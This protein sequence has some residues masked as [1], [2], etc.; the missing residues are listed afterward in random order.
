[1]GFYG[2]VVSWRCVMR[3]KKTTEHDINRR[4]PACL[5]AD[6][7][8]NTRATC[9]NFKPKFVGIIVNSNPG[10]FPETF[11]DL[12][13]GFFRDFFFFFFGSL[14]GVFLEAWQLFMGV[15]VR[16]WCESWRGAGLSPFFFIGYNRSI[17]IWIY[18]YVYKQFGKN[19]NVS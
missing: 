14:V 8:C 2:G 19:K 15:L 10:N 17:Y 12:G 6:F 7:P 5:N 3:L 13:L 4:S 16:R 1:M 11:H 18:V 9:Y